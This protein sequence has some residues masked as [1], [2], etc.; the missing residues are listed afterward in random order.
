MHET[1]LVNLELFG[2]TGAAFDF[3]FCFLCFFGVVASSLS[4]EVASLVLTTSI[5]SYSQS[6]PEVIE[7]I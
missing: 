1:Y 5:Y 7:N 2:H 4:L 3:F 6:S